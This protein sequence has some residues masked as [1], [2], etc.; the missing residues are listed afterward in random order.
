MIARRIS[1]VMGGLALG[2]VVA[3]VIGAL[4]F[5]AFPALRRAR[6]PIA[7][8][9]SG[10][11]VVRY[12][13]GS[14]LASEAEAVASEVNAAWQD[15]LEKLG[16]GLAEIRGPVDV[17]LYASTAELPLGYA[18]RTEE[19]RTSVAVVDHVWGQPLGGALGR[20]A[21]SLLFGR[22]GNAV[23]R[24][25]LALYLDHPDHPWAV[26]AAA[27]GEPVPWSILWE[28]ADRLL[29][30]DPWEGLY[31]TV[32]APWVGVAPS[33]ETYRALI[34]ARGQGSQGR[35]R[36]WEARAGALGE[37]VLN[38]FGRRGV[39]AFWQAPSWAA[40]A[41][42][43]GMSP[44]AMAAELDAY[45][46]V[47]FAESPD[48][49][50]L[51]AM[52]LLYSGRTERA[53]AALHALSGEEV[54]WALGLAYLALGD[55]E[56]AETAWEGGEAHEPEL[57]AA[58]GTLRGESRLTHG[59]LVLVGPAEDGARWLAAAEEALARA[60]DFWEIAEAGLPDKLVF[61]LVSTVPAATVPWGVVW[62]T[63]GA[64][65][66]P[67]LAVRVALEAVSPWGLPAYRALVEGVVLHLAYPDRD[68]RAEAARILAEGRWVSLAQPLFEIYPPEVAEAEAGALARFLAERYGPQGVRAMWALLDAGASPFRA[69]EQGLGI[70]LLELEK[71]LKAWLRQP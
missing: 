52:T 67:S 50:Y 23:F 29:P 58:V 34:L 36:T 63:A 69:A 39:E 9:Q 31:F 46:A 38:R 11:V 5:W 17:Y 12:L 56:R 47:S 51:R 37:W 28:R 42:A 24:R 14:A 35:G 15:V 49:P 6:S 53:L 27:W 43:L 61:Y 44:E 26:E 32:N 40:A 68:F 41:T 66:L 45:L 60:M 70:A 16:I 3:L 21:C 25:G 8:I 22:P 33:L 48:A 19:E 54:S 62:V 10:P 59:R 7:E 55:P 4:V 64:E 71:E 57:R 13:K 20:L 65:A 1:W 2:A 18:A 30:Q